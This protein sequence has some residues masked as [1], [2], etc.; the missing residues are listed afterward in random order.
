MGGCAFLFGGNSTISEQQKGAGERQSGR[1]L[2][3]SAKGHLSGADDSVHVW[4]FVLG[5][6]CLCPFSFVLT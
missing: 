4:N 6:V 1:G 3:L 2:L 5:C